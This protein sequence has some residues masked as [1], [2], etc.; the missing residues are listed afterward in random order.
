[1]K[2]LPSILLML[3]TSVSFAQVQQ[4][5]SL[6]TQ[7][8]E[9]VRQ[10]PHEQPSAISSQLE[11]QPLQDASGVKAKNWDKKF[12]LKKFLAKRAAKKL[13]KVTPIA[14]AKDA[15]DRGRSLLYV[16]LVVILVLIILNLI[17]DLLPFV[18]TGALLLVLLIILLLWLLGAI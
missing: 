11:L 9:V 18:F 2:H 7:E 4:D 13:K 12:S 1:M 17:A 3:I 10:V 8:A 14:V 15:Q 6:G 5:R 16:L